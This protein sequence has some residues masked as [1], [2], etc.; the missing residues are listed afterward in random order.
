M[1]KNAPFHFSVGNRIADV[2]KWCWFVVIFVTL[3]Y[4]FYDVRAENIWQWMTKPVA[5]RSIP[6]KCASVYFTGFWSL[7]VIHFVYPLWNSEM[8]AQELARR[9]HHH[10]HCRAAVYFYV[11]SLFIPFQFFFSCLCVVFH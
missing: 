9:R 6:F 8:L 7:F 10:H 4:G 2:L 1:H 3:T 11:H 5:W